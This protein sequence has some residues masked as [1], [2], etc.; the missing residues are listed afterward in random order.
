[1]T[2]ESDK[3][4]SKPENRATGYHSGSVETVI[5]VEQVAREAAAIAE[6]VSAEQLDALVEDQTLTRA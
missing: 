5:S 4:E 3:R 6:D 1:M 2:A